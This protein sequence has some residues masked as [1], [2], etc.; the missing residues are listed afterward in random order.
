MKEKV[1]VNQAL[2][3]GID[4][5]KANDLNTAEIYFK[6]ILQ[7]EPNHPDANHNMGILVLG[8]NN[9]AEAI[10]Y[11]VRAIDQDP[12]IPTFWISYTHA[13]DK[14][15]HTKDAL[16]Q[17][18][19]AKDRGIDDAKLNAL[20]GML[21]QKLN[22]AQYEEPKVP[23]YDTMDR[24]INLFKQGRYEEVFTSSKFLT[25]Q[26]H[27]SSKLWNL[28]GASAA[29]TGNLD[30]ALIGFE[31]AIEINPLHSFAHNNMGNVLREKG[32][33]TAAIQAYDLA[34]KYNSK[35]AEA[36]ISKGKLQKK[37]RKYTDAVETFL[38]LIAIDPNSGEA[39]NN[40][41]VTYRDQG[42]LTKAEAAFKEALRLRPECKITLNNLGVILQ[43]QGKLDDAILRYEMAE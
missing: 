13:L 23:P 19:K 37:L 10:Q 16:M 28:Y 40:L 27:S 38:N 9:F 4:A 41:G 26:Y 43:E 17:I 32:Q 6:M 3:R 29:E 20:E 33:I 12:S 31:K 30:Q 22:Y 1:T 21:I 24:L 36:Y 35:L 15:G 14:S 5:Y 39:H 2:Q 25:K 11:F 18:K 8:S 42:D 34:I 7:K